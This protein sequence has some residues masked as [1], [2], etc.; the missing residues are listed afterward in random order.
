MAGQ[1]REPGTYR[2]LE[3]A[4]DHCDGK[5]GVVIATAKDTTARTREIAEAYPT[6]MMM[7]LTALNEETGEFSA[8]LCPS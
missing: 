4:R 6:K 5:F 3:W 2:K 7:R 1:T 8:E